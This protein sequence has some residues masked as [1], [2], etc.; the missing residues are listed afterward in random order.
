MKIHEIIKNQG[1]SVSFEFFPPK[2]L[3]GENRLLPV[4]KKLEALAVKGTLVLRCITIM[5]EFGIPE[6]EIE[7]IGTPPLFRNIPIQSEK[8]SKFFGLF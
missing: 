1:K 2:D 3:A 5:D 6:G 4:I 7:N 8:C